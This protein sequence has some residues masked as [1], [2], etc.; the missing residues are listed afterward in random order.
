[1]S[2]VYELLRVSFEVSIFYYNPNIMPESEYRLR[3]DELDR[4]TGTKKI[5]FYCGDY[6]VREWVQEVH[7]YRYLGERSPRCW[8]CYRIRLEETFKKAKE[9]DM[10][11]VSSALSISPHKDVGQINKIGRE[12]QEKYHIEFYEAD[13]KKKDGFK[14]SIELSKENDFYRQGYCGCIYSKLERDFS[15]RWRQRVELERAAALNT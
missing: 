12:L 3:K 13:F 7:K 6:N 9:L 14:K 10:D 11:I 2:Y 5:P 1:M 4:Y 8:E 15:S